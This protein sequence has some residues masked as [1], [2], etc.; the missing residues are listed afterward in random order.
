MSVLAQ[1]FAATFK[2][3]ASPPPPP[4]PSTSII[5]T[6]NTP[7]SYTAPAGNN[8]NLVLSGSYVPPPAA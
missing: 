8:V 3:A 4:P 2:A 1:L 5:F 7:G 6:L